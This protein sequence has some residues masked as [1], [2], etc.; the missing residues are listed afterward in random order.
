[1]FELILKQCYIVI[2]L[3]NADIFN[4]PSEDKSLSHFFN[5][6][7]KK[8]QHWSGF[9]FVIM[10]VYNNKLERDLQH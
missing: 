3:E 2:P 6:Q 8:V 9:R 1:M 4:P 5:N 10:Q 7:I